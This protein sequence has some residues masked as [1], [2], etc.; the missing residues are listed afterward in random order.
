MQTCAHFLFCAHCAHRVH[1]V[2]TMC[3][4]CT[5]DVQR[6]SSCAEQTFRFSFIA[7]LNIL[8]ALHYAAERDTKSISEVRLGGSSAVCT[9]CTVR[10]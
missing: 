7:T 6:L 3:T 1:A 9:V 4:L 8:T 5:L 2:H 10:T